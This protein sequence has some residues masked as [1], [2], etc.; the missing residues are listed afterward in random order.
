MK[1]L[2]LNVINIYIVNCSNKVLSN[3]TKNEL[4]EKNLTANNSIKSYY[5][6]R[7]YTTSCKYWKEESKEWSTDGC[8]VINHFLMHEKLI[9]SNFL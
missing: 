2:F 7:L 5:S 4:R 6:V 8:E 3:I 1:F 9:F